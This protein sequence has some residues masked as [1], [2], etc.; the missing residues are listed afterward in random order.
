V[1]YRRRNRTERSAGERRKEKGERRKEKGRG[2]EWCGC[3][4]DVSQI[5]YGRGKSK[6]E[7]HEHMERRGDLNV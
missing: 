1:R 4:K 2:G 6:K 5:I 3:E 7:C